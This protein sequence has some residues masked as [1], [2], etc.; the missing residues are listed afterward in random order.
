MATPTQAR[1]VSTPKPHLPNTPSGMLASPR[2]GTSGK[3][4]AYKSPAAA[5]KTPASMHLHGLSVSSQPSSTPLGAAAIHDELLN[6]NSPAAA[7]INSIAQ[8]NLTPVPMG[9]QDGLGMTGHTPL[10]VRDEPRS[11]ETERLHRLQQALDKLKC[12]VIGRNV[13]R[14]GIKRVAQLNGLEAVDIDDDNLV[15]AGEN[16]VE[17]EITFDPVQRNDVKDLCLKLNYDDQT[18]V[19]TESTAMLKAQVAADASVDALTNFAHNV[20][21]LAQ[22][23]KIDVK[24]NCFQLVNNLSACLQDVWKEEKKRMHWRDELHHLRRGAVG[25]PIMDRSPRLGLGITYWQKEQASRAEQLEVS[26]SDQYRATVSCESGL[27]TMIAFE[28]WLKDDIL[29]EAQPGQNVL[30]AKDHVFYPIGAIPWPAWPSQ[31]RKQKTRHPWKWTK[32]APTYRSR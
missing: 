17:M 13:T 31:L 19:Q 11:P 14:D 2:P 21:Y 18:H 9:P 12:K 32:K 6:L 5:M 27:P 3:K 24:P 10:T 15:V 22:L 28:K 29:A 8:N 16:V 1:A 25:M 20:E 4:L 7:L 26:E 30:D 23:E